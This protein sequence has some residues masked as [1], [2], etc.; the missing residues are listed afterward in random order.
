MPDP[1]DPLVRNLLF[2]HSLVRIDVPHRVVTGHTRLS[3]VANRKFQRI[4]GDL[5]C[6]PRD[7]RRL[8][9]IVIRYGA[10]VLDSPLLTP[11]FDLTRFRKILVAKGS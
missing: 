10:D 8:V 5:L 3:E 6:L 7:E 2:R 1:F 4:G 9:Q 11:D